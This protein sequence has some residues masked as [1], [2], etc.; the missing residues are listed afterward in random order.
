MKHLFTTLLVLCTTVVFA[1]EF[2]KEIVQ[3]DGKKFMVGKINLEG[4]HAEPYQQW[5]HQGMKTYPVDETLVKL[6]KKDLAQYNIKL[7]LG[8]WCGDSKRETPRFIKILEAADFPMEQLEIIALD[9][10]KEHYKK[11]P[12]GEEKGLNIIKVPTMVF[13]KN[14]AEINRIVER[15]IASLEEDMAQ[16]VQNKPYIPN[17]AQ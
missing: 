1:Q 13:F 15:P 11:S 3:E 2:N 4:L 6:F 9:R 17:Y 7:F 14:G 10:R 8:T 12:T 5:F 16:I